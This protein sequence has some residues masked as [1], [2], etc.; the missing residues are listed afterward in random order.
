MSIKLANKFLEK[1]KV[2]ERILAKIDEY[3]EQEENENYELVPK[4]KN[5]RISSIF[6]IKERQVSQLTLDCVTTMVIYFAAFILVI[7]KV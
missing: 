1:N 5:R 2:N 7:K 3:E 6:R 4:I